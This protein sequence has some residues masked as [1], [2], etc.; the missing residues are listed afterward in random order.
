RMHHEAMRASRTIDDLLELSR[1]EAGDSGQRDLV[2]VHLVLAEA[3]ERAATAAEQRGI[4]IDVA[5]P[6]RRLSVLG[7]R[8]QLVSAV[9]N[10]VE[11][12]VKYSATGSSVSLAASGDDHEVRI[13]VADR[14]IGIPRRD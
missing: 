14:G 10:L 1:I 13:A 8:R 4:A 12:A 11:N 6:P 5:E 9:F 7:D 2:P 3:A